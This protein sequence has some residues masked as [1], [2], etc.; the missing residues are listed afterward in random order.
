MKHQSKGQTSTPGTASPSFCDQC[1]GS[2]HKVAMN[3]GC[4][5]GP[6]VCRPHPK[7]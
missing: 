2:S 5:T 7:V 3:K 6:T 4:E 1:V